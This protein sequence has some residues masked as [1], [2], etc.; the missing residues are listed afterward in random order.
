MI[1]V[2][3]R[4]ASE[5]PFLVLSPKVFNAVMPSLGLVFLGP[6]SEFQR[7][8]QLQF[9]VPKCQLTVNSGP[10][11]RWQKLDKTNTGKKIS[12]E[13]KN[14]IRW[15]EARGMFKALEMASKGVIYSTYIY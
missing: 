3:L 6:T 9:V 15:I 7:I 14:S 4:Q 5:T 2:I 10:G 11:V 13:K 8:P 1:R 12:K